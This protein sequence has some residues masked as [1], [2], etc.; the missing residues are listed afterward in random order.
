MRRDSGSTSSEKPQYFECERLDPFPPHAV[1]GLLK[2]VFSLLIKEPRTSQR[3][4]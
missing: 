1:L 3:L 2:E 4:L